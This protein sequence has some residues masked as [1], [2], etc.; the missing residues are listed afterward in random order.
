MRW[1]MLQWVWC[2]C[3]SLAQCIAWP[4]DL[5]STVGRGI[6]PSLPP[7]GLPARHSTCCSAYAWPCC[8]IL[9]DSCPCECPMCA[10]ARV[11]RSTDAVCRARRKRRGWIR[12]RIPMG[13][14]TSSRSK[15]V[16][17][18]ALWS[19]LFA[20]ER[21]NRFHECPN[22]S[23]GRASLRSANSRAV[24]RSTLAWRPPSL[25]E[26]N[27]GATAKCGRGSRSA[28]MYSAERASMCSS[29]T[30]RCCRSQKG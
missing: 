10:K 4:I 2:R 7:C 17:A 1:R 25:D 26:H 29:R 8:N 5:S 9:T 23:V 6:V 3:I 20:N 14:T 18:A 30:H 24:S 13:R 16:A 19:H 15:H 22:R 11:A 12:A 21:P 28:L 27:F